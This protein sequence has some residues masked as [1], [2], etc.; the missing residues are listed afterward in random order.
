MECNKDE[1]TS[2]QPFPS[3]PP[4]RPEIF[5]SS[6]NGCRLQYEYLKMYLNHN[7]IFPYCL[8]PFLATENLSP[9]SVKIQG[10]PSPWSVLLQKQQGMFAGTGSRSATFT[11]FRAT[12]PTPLIQRAR[13]SLKDGM[14]TV[15]MA[16]S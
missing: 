1:A 16:G 10:T 7:L 2:S 5:W 11:P 12:P 15:A 3:P 9:S 13:E 14:K 4:S 8:Q 6:C